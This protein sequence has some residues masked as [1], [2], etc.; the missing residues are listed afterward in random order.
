MRLA[1]VITAILAG[2]GQPSHG[3][4]GRLP[5]VPAQTG[6]LQTPDRSS[7]S[8]AGEGV[9]A[10][11][12]IQIDLSTP[13]NAALTWA[14]WACLGVLP[15]T[16]EIGEATCASDGSK[17]APVTAAMADQI[18]TGSPDF[19]TVAATEQPR[20]PGCPSLTLAFY[21]FTPHVQIRLVRPD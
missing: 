5:T 14:P 15:P 7:L 12:R 18:C 8:L 20:I 13:A 17:S 10:G 11:T 9:P 19:T 2:C 21:G 3:D 4:A 1:L 16:Q 6:P